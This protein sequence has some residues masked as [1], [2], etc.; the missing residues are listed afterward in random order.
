MRMNMLTIFFISAGLAMDSLAVSITMGFT[1]NRCNIR[2]AVLIA[3]CFGLFQSVMPIGGWLGG[4]AIS[5][6]IKAWDH[7]A[8]LGLLSFIGIKMIYESKQLESPGKTGA[9]FSLKVLLLLSLATSIDA[10]AVGVTFAVLHSGIFS[11]VLIIGLVTF[12]FCLS[13]VYIG[14]HFGHLFESKIEVAGGIILILMGI[15]I[16]AEHI[17]QG[18]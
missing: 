14:K 10:F 3:F 11:A 18:I 2:R 15:K 17:V 7:W 4:L 8:A 9:N 1:L 5:G 6:W 12:G 16:V 13:G